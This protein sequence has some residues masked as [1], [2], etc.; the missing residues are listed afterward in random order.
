MLPIIWHNVTDTELLCFETVRY[1]GRIFF[2]MIVTI[3]ERRIVLH[4]NDLEVELTS[5]LGQ[6]IFWCLCPSKGA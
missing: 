4:A 6:V 5:E 1:Q 3:Q 2:L